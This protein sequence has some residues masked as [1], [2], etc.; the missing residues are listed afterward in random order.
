MK[1]LSSLI[2][3]LAVALA[4]PAF[5]GGGSTGTA[6]AKKRSKARTAKVKKKKKRRIRVKRRRGYRG[7]GVD[8]DDL[9]KTPLPKPSGDIWIWSPNFREELRVNIFN[10]DGSFNQEALAKL[11]N[12]FRC[13]RTDEVRAVDP[14][15]Y[16]ILSIIFDHFD[17]NRIELTSGFRFQKNQGSRHYHASAMDIRVEGASM[18]ELYDFA[19]SLDR[20]GMG[21][22]IYPRSGFIHVDLR[23]PGEPSYRWTDYSG[24][25]RQ[26]ARRR[27]PR[28]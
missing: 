11:D 6:H 4:A 24:P 7:H 22:G 10:A 27:G 16:V 28:G 13:K 17:G 20:G 3:S 26:R 15:L 23:A 2:L 1:L 8:V 25:R 14:K 21:I 12:G 19:E 5:S 9:R 18:R